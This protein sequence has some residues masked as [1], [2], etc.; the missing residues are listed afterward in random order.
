MLRALLG[1]EP[2]WGPILGLASGFST[3]S[4]LF[5][6]FWGFAGAPLLPGLLRHENGRVF[7]A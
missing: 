6:G 7:Y 1:L 4:P 3:P 2:Q 5:Q